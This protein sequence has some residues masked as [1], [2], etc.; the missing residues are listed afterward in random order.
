MQKARIRL[1]R[2]EIFLD[3]SKFF[4]DKF[5][6]IKDSEIC[7]VFFNDSEVVFYGEKSQFLGKLSTDELQQLILDGS[8]R[9][10]PWERNL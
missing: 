9:L 5:R 3:K 1:A 7:Y 8:V 6:D 4:D 2:K 10:M